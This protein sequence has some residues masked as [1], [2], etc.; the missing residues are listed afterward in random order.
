MPTLKITVESELHRK[1]I[2]RISSRM[3][4]SRQNQSKQHVRWRDA[5]NRMVA[6]IPE[7][8]M[9]AKRRQRRDRGEPQYTTIQ[10]PYTF[11]V[12]M[13]A[14]T[15]WT[16]VFFGRNPIHQ[17]SGRNG[18]GEMQ[19]QAM[20][21]LVQY[22]V[23]VGRMLAPYYLWLYDA[24]K[25]GIGIIG[26]YWDKRVTQYG[27]IESDPQSGEM[28]QVSRQVPGYQGN[29]AYNVSPYDFFHDPR[30]TVGNFQRGEFLGVET[31][32]AWHEIKRS[33]ARGDYMNVDKITAQSGQYRGNGD[34]ENSSS[35]V[36]RP[37]D[38]LW[39]LSGE[40][41]EKPARVKVLEFY[42]EIS[43]QEWGV[44]NAKSSEK[45]CFT[46][47]ADERLIIGARPLGAIHGEFPFGVIE[48][49]LEAYG[50]YNRGL[51]ELVD[52]L[53]RTMDWLINTHFYNVRSALN[54]QF[55]IDPSR[56]HM[57]DAQ[58]GGPGFIFRFRPEAYGSDVRTAMAQ[59]QVNDVTQA[60]MRDLDA[61]LAIGE[62]MTG[63]N[64]QMFGV[65]ANGGRK[66]ATEI[67]TST[68]FGTNR[69]K[70]QTEWMSV[71]GFSPHAQQIT[72]NTLQY[73][74]GMQKVRIVGEAAKAAGM[75]F[76]QVAPETIA[77]EYD[78]VAVDGTL[79]VD[80]F[81][82]VT[83][84]KD[85]LSTLVSNPIGQQV[86]LQYDMAKL[87]GWVFSLGGL[88]N[89]DQF[90]VQVA[91]PGVDPSQLGGNVIPM[92]IGGAPPAMLENSPAAG[93]DQTG[94]QI[95]A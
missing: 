28:V 85:L 18:T 14:H 33:E 45:W 31:S 93:G 35:Q 89:I 23:D 48:S 34:R 39:A 19:V 71:S 92:N 24:A 1:L 11:A 55:L 67:R 50:V 9:D 70:T 30:V 51:T 26:I 69:Q 41:G 94:G 38:S 66:T 84:W 22:Q 49:E 59:F 64:E 25:Y 47:T 78:F 12:V 15:Y 83:M 63:I 54:N 52:P 62:R 29:C 36:E 74:D 77:G 58:K 37:D 43:P 57:K 2:S 4:I 42:C 65:L 56:V 13:T 6:Y 73:Y 53:Q 91:P 7:S 80:R 76:I 27:S 60:H 79:P 72:A 16:S 40:E 90:R 20:E 86:M 87:F 81:A 17:Y 88:K 46:L 95:Y 68:G 75:Q 61:M 44:G 8:I 32:L 10:I 82:Q 3:K 5:E 21:A